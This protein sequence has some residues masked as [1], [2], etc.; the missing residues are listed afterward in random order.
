MG[1]P[2]EWEQAAFLIVNTPFSFLGT[3][4]LFLLTPVY[5]VLG[6][7]KIPLMLLLIVMSVVFAVLLGV[8]I[9][10]S[11]ISLRFSWSRPV[12]FVFAL[13]F[14]ICAHFLVSISPAPGQRDAEAKYAK[15]ALIESFP[16]C[17]ILE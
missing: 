15:W 13:P 16:H 12:V 3:V 1:K 14:L 2:T 17:S 6:L 4:T 10:F 9:G 8:I 11:K 5:M 7:L